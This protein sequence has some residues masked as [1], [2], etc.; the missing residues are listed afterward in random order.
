[1]NDCRDEDC[2]DYKRRR[3]LNCMDKCHKKKTSLKDNTEPGDEVPCS[4]ELDPL[5]PTREDIEQMARSNPVL[6]QSI[7][8]GAMQKLNWVETM[9]LA[10]KCLIEYSDAQNKKMIKIVELSG[11]P[12]IIK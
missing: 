3:L 2:E 9:H 10:V 12:L 1:M 6:R 11:K 5:F 4:A 7:I 8:M